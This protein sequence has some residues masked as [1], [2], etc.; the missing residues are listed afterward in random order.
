M[1]FLDIKELIQTKIKELVQEHSTCDPFR[2]CKELQI[3][4]VYFDLGEET[5]GIIQ[6]YKDDHIICINNKLTEMEQQ[7][8]CAHELGHFILHKNIN[9][10]FLKRCTFHKTDRYEIEA[11]LFASTL[12]DL[13]YKNF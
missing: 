7:F 13:L 1:I 2:L 6:T 10:V 11:D 4:L 5:R 3:E 12:L 8:V 9:T